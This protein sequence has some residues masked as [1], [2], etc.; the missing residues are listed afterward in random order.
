MRAWLEDQSAVDAV[1]VY[2]V[3]YM[4][5]GCGLT[6]D[7]ALVPDTNAADAAAVIDGA[8]EK[9]M[10][11]RHVTADYFSIELEW[12]YRSASLTHYGV[13]VYPR[14]TSDDELTEPVR[15]R[16]I[17]LIGIAIDLAQ[18]GAESVTIGSNSLDVK[19]GKVDAVP[20]DLLAT[21]SFSDN[22]ATVSLNDRFTMNGW[23]V[24][25]ESTADNQPPLDAIDQVTAIPPA[26]GTERG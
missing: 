10:E 24:Q 23:E 9:A 25:I 16:R 5:T 19:R 18:S 17:E 1:D 26:P 12:Q 2:C 3:S 4:E 14:T 21:T 15:A 6:A 22:A 13:I 11:D 20:T 7:V 8:L